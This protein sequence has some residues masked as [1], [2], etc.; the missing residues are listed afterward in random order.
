MANNIQPSRKAYM[1]TLAET[2]SK[3]INPKPYHTK[4][5]SNTVRPPKKC[6]GRTTKRDTMV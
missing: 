6:Q 4:L 3:Q 5:S 2:M 1:N